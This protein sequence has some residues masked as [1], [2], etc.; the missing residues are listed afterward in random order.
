MYVWVCVRGA[1]VCIHTLHTYCAKCIPVFMF[2][3]VCRP[4]VH[5]CDGG[6][7]LVD[8]GGA[9]VSHLLQ[10]P[11]RGTTLCIDISSVYKYCV[12]NIYDMYMYNISYG[13]LHP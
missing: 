9:H 7:Y 6:S 10:K 11:I 5:A 2:T 8:A 3:C 4:S 13:K 1:Y 12:N